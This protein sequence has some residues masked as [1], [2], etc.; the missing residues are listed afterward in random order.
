MITH[1]ERC[2]AI[3]YPS[4]LK[5]CPSEKHTTAEIEAKLQMP[6]LCSHHARL[7]QVNASSALMR[8]LPDNNFLYRHDN[9]KAPKEGAQD[10]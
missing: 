1:I 2:R 3:T 7:W 10:D 8:A 5:Q 6:P 9:M 4:R